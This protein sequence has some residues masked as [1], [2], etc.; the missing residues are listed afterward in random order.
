[1]VKVSLPRV[2]FTSKCPNL[3]PPPCRPEAGQRAAQVRPHLTQWNGGKG[4]KEACWFWVDPHMLHDMCRQCHCLAQYVLQLAHLAR[5]CP[6]NKVTFNLLALY[7][8]GADYYLLPFSHPTLGRLLQVGD[9]GMSIK[10]GA[11]ETHASGVHHG[12]PLY[13]APE[14]LHRWASTLSKP[15]CLSMC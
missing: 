8:L 4:G 10:L 15:P 7:P 9:F 12:T 13:I 5:I 3:I 11:N 14:I 1:M 6:A 2:P